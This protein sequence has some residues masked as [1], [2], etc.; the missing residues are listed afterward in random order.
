MTGRLAGIPY[1]GDAGIAAGACPAASELGSVDVAAGAGS[2]PL[3][4]GGHVHLAG[5][6]KGAPLSLAVLTPAVAGPFDL[7]TVAVRVALHVDRRSARVRAVSDP[8]PTILRGIPLDIRSLTVMLDRPGFTL[9]PTSCAPTSVAATSTS[10]LGWPAPL[11]E[12]FQAASC[13]GLGFKPAVSVRL[14]GPTRRGAHPRLRTVLTPRPGDANV[15]RVAV[16][17]PGTELLDNRHLGSICTVAR[18]AA[19]NCPAGSIYGH[20]KAWTPLL[21]KPLEGPVY[22][23]ASGTKLPDLA[24]SLD[25]Q[26]QLDLIGRV[27]SVRGRLRNTFQALPD[28]PLSRVVLTLK[29]GR[30]GLLVNTGGLCARKHRAGAS[31]AGQN[32]KLYDLSP[33]VK[34]DCGSRRTKK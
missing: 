6:Y 11:A 12:R 25:G 34:T 10:T 22:L 14:L 24:A 17:L 5:P 31:L 15:R 16:T 20:A 23:R 13:A 30:K 8:L 28:A 18:F 7:G 32:G 4:L 21:D 1:C 29:G 27:D 26:I 19:G 9:N 2:S 33:I 3:H